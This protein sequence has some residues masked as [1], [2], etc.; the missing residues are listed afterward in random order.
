VWVKPHA[1][2]AKEDQL[3]RLA[4]FVSV[5]AVVLAWSASA[6]GGSLAVSP[7]A[8]PSSAAAVLANAAAST[9][10]SGSHAEA[11]WTYAI[12]NNCANDLAYCWNEFTLPDLRALPAN[13]SVNVVVMIKYLLPRKGVKLLKISGGHLQ[14]VASWPDKDF[15]SS[16]TFAW[17]LRQVHTRFPSEHLAID[18]SDHGYGWRYCSYD[19]LTGHYLTTPRLRAAITKAAVPI[20]VLSFDC[21]NMADIDAVYDIGLTGLVKYVVASEEEIDQDGI[22]YDNALAPLLKDPSLTPRQVAADTVTGWQRYFRSLRCQNWGSL[23]SIDV[24]K[25]MAA[26]PDLVAWVARLHADLGRFR[27]RYKAALH[28]SYYA[29]ESWQVD[30]ADVASRLAADPKITDPTLR[31]LSAAVATDVRAATV[32]LW[33]GSY[34][35]AFTGMTLWWG[36]RG[37]WTFFRKSYAQRIAFG[38]QVG[39]L[40]FLKAYNVGDHYPPD[41]SGGFPSGWPQPVDH[42]ATYG[43]QDVVFANAN[44]GWATGYMNPTSQVVLMHTTDGGRHWKVTSPTVWDC[45]TIASLS[46][47]DARHA[48][49]VGSQIWAN[50]RNYNAILRTADGG[51]HWRLQHGGKAEYLEST[52]FV[53]KHDG[54]IAGTDGTLLHTT[55]GGAHWS[56]PSAASNTDYWSVDFLNNHDGWLAGGD[57]STMQGVVKHTSDGGA[58]WSNTTVAGAVLYSVCGLSAAEAWAVGGDPAGG[59]GVILHTTNSGATWQVQDG[60]AAVPW[61]GHVTFVNAADGWVVGEHGAVLH[62]INGGGTWT[63]VDV[64]A[65]DDLTAVCFTSPLNGWIVGDGAGLL[66]TTDG[67]LTWTPVHVAGTK[68]AITARNEKR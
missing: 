17:F 8:A 7:G 41:L 21:C 14:V 51:A 13:P 61:L 11:A 48:W 19:T 38:H 59:N 45:Y 23:S 56:G 1:R 67:G 9:A 55:D 18:D 28:H 44:D 29:E 15:G 50:N 46:P 6:S 68:A 43:L 42:R 26:K 10:S 12:Y 64:G 49:A 31:S 53:N 30:L 20:D 2:Q 22:P 47:L 27:A 24:A 34:A 40:S 33:S 5:C 58:T 52:D 60:G 57:E 16:Q 25:L 65:T 4:V 36:T 66:H 62:T 54:W 32:N 39:W 35:S 63:P 37:E 3:K